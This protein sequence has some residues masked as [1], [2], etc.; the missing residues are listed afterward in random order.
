LPPPKQR[1]RQ[2]PCCRISTPLSNHLP[3]L[4]FKCIYSRPEAAWQLL[5]FYSS[6]SHA[7]AVSHPCLA[8]S[9]RLQPSAR[10]AAAVILRARDHPPVALQPEVAAVTVE[11]AAPLPPRSPQRQLLKPVPGRISLPSPRRARA[12]RIRRMLLWSCTNEV[13]SAKLKK[14]KAAFQRGLL[15]ECH[16]LISQSAASIFDTTGLYSGIF[17]SAP[18]A[19]AIR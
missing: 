15:L 11:A 6:A 5:V 2:Q 1:R 3:Y 14:K 9:C 4:L 7:V 17:T 10:L 13:G 18:S 16:H 19:M 8:S 12:L